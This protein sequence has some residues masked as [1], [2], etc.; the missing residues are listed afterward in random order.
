MRLLCSYAIFCYNDW[1]R[2][3]YVSI[4]NAYIWKRCPEICE[5]RALSYSRMDGEKGKKP[6]SFTSPLACTDDCCNVF[7][8]IRAFQCGRRKRH[9]ND[10]WTRSFW[11]VFENGAFRK[12]IIVWTGPQTCEW[13]INWNMNLTCIRAYRRRVCLSSICSRDRYAN[14]VKLFL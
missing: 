3:A 1:K 9:V 4:E 12:C 2:W 13:N 11:C 5:N 8:G 14:R 10:N 7:E 6:T